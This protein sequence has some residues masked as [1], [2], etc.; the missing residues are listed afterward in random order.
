D[1]DMRLPSAERVTVVVRAMALGA[2]E[3]DAR[4]YTGRRVGIMTDSTHT[5]A[6]IE[7]RTAERIKEALDQGIIPVV[8]GFQGIN[9]NN[10][11]P[12][13]GRGGSDLT[14]VALAAALRA[15]QC[16]IYTDV[17]GIF[18]ADPNIVP[19]ARK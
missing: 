4:A 8:A 7:Q 1:L 2:I 5:R 3:L 6:R 12:T 13:L 18:T 15:E 9:E 16:L 10:D 14:A 17:E 11:V 19:S